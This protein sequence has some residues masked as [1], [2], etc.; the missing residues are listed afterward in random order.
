MKL[1]PFLL[2]D[3]LESRANLQFNLAGSTGPRW[4]LEELQQLGDP[5]LDLTDLP[6]SY[7][8]PA[9]MRELRAE[10]AAH[11]NVDP[12]W[13]VVTNGASEAF[14]LLLSVLSRPQGNVLLPMPTYPAFAGM[15]QFVHLQPRY[16]TM[17]RDRNFQIDPGQLLDAA[18]DGTVLVV[19]NSPQNPTGA[20]LKPEDCYSL[21]DALAKKGMPLL[22]DE[23]FHPVYFGAGNPSAAGVDNV[24]VIGDM[25]K[26]FS[27]PGLRIGWIVDADAERRANIVRAR[28]YISLSGS[29]VSE[30]LAFHA[31]QNR[32]KVLE[33][34]N[35]VAS[36][37]LADLQRFMATVG[38]VLDWV[39]PEA[40]ML[41]F[42]WFRDGRN[43]RIFCERIADKG[44]FV[45]P[46]DCFGMP[47]HMRFGFGSQIG[48][49]AG[50]FDIMAEELRAS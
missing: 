18:D 5:S 22:V 16:Y 49:I 34:V 2:N 24:I 1:P 33:R 47:E 10:I 25:S 7:A 8:P 37:N 41:A 38:D 40:G 28:S 6:I 26:A 3:W 11:H 4:T 31:L 20:L 27:M 19:T 39:P 45:A 14:L 48:G 43:S 44:V 21:S 15:A 42:P 35:A 23:V 32:G 50:A 17:P 46:G 36:A 30:A 12:D 29:P 9:G 13:V